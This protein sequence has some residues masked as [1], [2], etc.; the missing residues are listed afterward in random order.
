M[1]TNNP[2]IQLPAPIELPFAKN[3]RK[4]MGMP[5]GNISDAIQPS[6]W[7]FDQNPAQASGIEQLL[8]PMR[9]QFSGLGQISPLNSGLRTY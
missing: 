2:I 4:R 1:L 6:Q 3:K 5:L 7:K 8:S 9:S